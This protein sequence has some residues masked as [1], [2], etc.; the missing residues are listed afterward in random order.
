M[1][2][3]RY[4]LFDDSGESFSPLDISNCEL[5]LNF[6]IPSSLI[7]GTGVSQWSDLSTAGRNLTMANGSLQPVL[8]ADGVLFD[9][10]DDF[11]EGNAF[12]ITSGYCFFIVS[13]VFATGGNRSIIANGNG[14]VGFSYRMNNQRNTVHNGVAL[15]GFNTFSTTNYEIV[16]ANW[17]VATQTLDL[18]V[19][20][21]LIIS[22]GVS[23]INDPVG[24]AISLGYRSTTAEFINAS[25]KGAICYSK[26]LSIEEIQNNFN[27]LN[28]EFLIY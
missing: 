5:Y 3:P 2:I 4:A 21:V 20:G 23:R 19:N 24:T 14:S 7:I 13:R 25:I 1:G 16:C 10:V 18:Y 28:K 9:G 26:A 12:P 22:Y 6:Q 8:N 11:L 15:Y 27:F 17:S